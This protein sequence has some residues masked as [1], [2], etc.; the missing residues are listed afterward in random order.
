MATKAGTLRT[1]G[2]GGAVARPPR[3]ADR[4]Q[5][6][7]LIGALARALSTARERRTLGDLRAAAEVGRSTG[8]RC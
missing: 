1:V 6:R 8:A 7:G 2:T 4:R 5:N 3:V